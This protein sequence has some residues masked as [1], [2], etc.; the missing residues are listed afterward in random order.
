M[1]IIVVLIVAFLGAFAG[2]LL[3]DL[4]PH[5]VIEPLRN[6]AQHKRLLDSET[7][8]AQW[9]ANAASFFIKYHGFERPRGRGR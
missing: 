6:R 1:D 8:R 2:S 7:F 4:V 5:Y 9:G 3:A